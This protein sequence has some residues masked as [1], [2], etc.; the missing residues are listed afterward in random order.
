MARISSCAVCHGDLLIPA[1]SQPLDQMRCP[2]CQAEFLVQDVLAASILAP[3]E[4]IPV[5]R[6][7][8]TVQA[9]VGPRLT[10]AEGSA[11]WDSQVVKSSPR[12]VRKQPGMVAIDETTVEQ[13]RD[14]IS[15]LI[16]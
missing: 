1:A 4:A 8:P 13:V 15:D 14:R 12:P 16:F 7:A 6:T 5:E 11:E 9:A 3:P 2:R 10:N